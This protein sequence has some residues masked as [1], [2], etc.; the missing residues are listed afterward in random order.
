M[1]NNFANELARTLQAYSKDVEK[2]VK[3]AENKV[4]NEA[5]TE[6]KQNSPQDTGSYAAGWGKT[7]VDGKTVIRNKTDPQLTHLLE[8]GHAKDG[9]G[10]VSGHP[11]IRPAKEKAVRNF[12]EEVERAIRS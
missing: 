6:I 11:H 8:H 12:T 3:Q 5:V 1:P 10:R 9:G 4:G 2:K 7:K